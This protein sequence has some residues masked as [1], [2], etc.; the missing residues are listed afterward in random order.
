MAKKVLMIDDDFETIWRFT[1][2]LAGRGYAVSKCADAAQAVDVF[3][4]EK[5][6]AVLLDVK[7]PGRSGFEVLRDIRARDPRVCVIMLSAYSEPGTV[8]EALK[9]KADNFADKA[10]GSEGLL[11]ILDKELR[12]KDLE[13]Q[14]QRLKSGNGQGLRTIDDI[15]GE[16][17]GIKA[18]KRQI[19]EYAE[20]SRDS[21]LTVF[22]TGESGVGKNVVAEALHMM[23][24]RRDKP[25]KHLLCSNLQSHL[26]ESELFG[27]EKGAFTDAYKS[28]KGLIDAADGGTMFLDEIGVLPTDIQAKLLLLTETG[29]Y[30]KLGAEGVSKTSEAW[31]I[32]ATNVD[33]PKAMRDG[34][35][36]EDLFYRLNQAWIHVPPLR[37][38]GDDVILLAEHFVKVESEKT[39]R[40]ALAL[41][42][43]Y[44]DSLLTYRWP[45]NVRQLQSVVRR[46]VKS[47]GQDQR[48]YGSGFESLAGPLET[49]DG[50]QNLKSAR[51]KEVEA[52]ERKR[53]VEALAR[54]GGNR[55]KAAKWLGISRRSL[56]Y[57]I[58]KYGL[59]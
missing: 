48:I 24:D 34:R 1:D 42:P 45:G 31:F 56:M 20:Y 53:I 44:T 29:V 10:Q 3:L 49:G 59:A 21:G 37:E 36:R 12:T 8:V 30:F 4:R 46:Y 25:F 16:S 15:I 51:A 39:G 19:R 52:F 14:V 13:A 35:F 9:L 18:V 22:I 43:A 55:T 40:S 58:K 6:D 26:V 47:Q 50:D 41:P 23:S 33:I 11:L 38:R 27:Y 5:P 7:M 2:A 54:F 28:K 57:K 32:T 17:E